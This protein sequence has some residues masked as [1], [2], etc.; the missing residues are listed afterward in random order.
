[1]DDE[2]S[3]P[4]EL[5]AAQQW[6][7]ARKKTYKELLKGRRYRIYLETESRPDLVKAERA[8]W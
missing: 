5:K 4:L 3:I 2:R 1:M 6:I 7:E 8:E